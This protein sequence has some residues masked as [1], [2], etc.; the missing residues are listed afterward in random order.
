MS[1]DRPFL[2]AFEQ[3]SRGLCVG[4]AEFLSLVFR[5]ALFTIYMRMFQL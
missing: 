3:V 2:A 4:L 1:V 5:L